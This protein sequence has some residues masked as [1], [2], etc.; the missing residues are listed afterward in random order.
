MV[1]CAGLRQADAVLLIFTLAA[2]APQ[3]MAAML[4]TAFQ[5]LAPVCVLV[6]AC[7][8]PSYP[9]H[10]TPCIIASYPLCCRGYD[11]GVWC[12]G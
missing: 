9:V 2:V 12:C 1:T 3:E 6:V 7:L 5:V 8:L 10:H 11:A 4:R